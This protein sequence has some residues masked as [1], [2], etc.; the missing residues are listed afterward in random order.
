MPLYDLQCNTCGNVTEAFQAMNQPQPTRCERC[1]KRKVRRVILKPP[2]AHNT[3]A[4][5]KPRKTRGRGY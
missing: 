4:P 1:G 3:Y 5:M 2:A